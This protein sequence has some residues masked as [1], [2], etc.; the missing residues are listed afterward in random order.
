MLQL[1]D[2]DAKG[3]FCDKECLPMPRSYFTCPA[4]NAALQFK[5]FTQLSAWLFRRLQI[6]AT[7]GKY[8]DPQTIC[9]NLCVLLKDVGV[10][11]ADSVGPQK[12]KA[13][14]GDSV[15]GILHSLVKLVLQRTNFRYV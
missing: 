1:L 13:G 9:T 7:W 6:E 15:L 4:A 8:D 12:L 5:Y 3:Q 14:W 2:Y 10:Q 11:G